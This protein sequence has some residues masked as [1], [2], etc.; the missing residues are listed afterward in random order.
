M[1]RISTVSLE[2]YG[3]LVE[4]WAELHQDEF[5]AIWESH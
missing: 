4:E 3:G 5:L 2:Y 1:K